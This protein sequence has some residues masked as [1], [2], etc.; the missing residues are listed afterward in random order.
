MHKLIAW[1]AGTVNCMYS[2]LNHTAQEVHSRRFCH[3]RIGTYMGVLIGVWAL[4]LGCAPYTDK[5]SAAPVYYIGT[6]DIDNPD[7]FKGYP[8]RVAELLPKYGG[9]VLASDTSAYVLE[10]HPRK[11][12]A[13][14]RFPS[15]DAALALYND[16]AYQEA[17]KIRQA[18]TSNITMVLVNEFQK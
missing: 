11:M 5:N 10:G 16:P 2:A 13:I 18:S 17:K 12:N 3:P 1:R 8:A 4:L 6:Y 14:I 9:Q 7:L 15:R